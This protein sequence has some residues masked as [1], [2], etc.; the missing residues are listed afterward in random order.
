MNAE[1][2]APVL[3]RCLVCR[4]PLADT[5]N[6]WVAEG[7]SD[8]EISRRLKGVNAYISRITIGKHR[9]AH[10]TEPA[11]RKRL[12]AERK[13]KAQQR[14]VKGPKV[15][16]LA[17]LVRDRVVSDVFSGKLNPS[18]AEGLRAQEILDRRAEKGADRSLILQLA[19]VLG[20]APVAG[21]IEGEYREVDPEALEDGEAMRLLTAG[22]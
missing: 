7:V 10:L 19:Q 20:G 13:L 5:I 21:Y 4:H 16:D 8:P 9:R 3:E 22:A 18:L 12:D 11:T 1:E 14:T 6:G 2:L 15:S 17:L